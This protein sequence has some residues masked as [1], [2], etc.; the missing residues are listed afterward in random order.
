MDKQG[1]EPEKKLEKVSTN[2][3]NSKIVITAVIVI[4]LGIIFVLV[5]ILF[6]MEATNRYDNEE[7]HSTPTPTTPAEDENVIVE[8]EEVTTSYNAD[9]ENPNHAK[10]SLM[11]KYGNDDSEYVIISSA[12]ELDEFVGAINSMNADAD[13]APFIYSVDSE[14]FTTGTVIAVAKEDAGLDKMAIDEVYRDGEYNI[15]IIGHY[16]SPYD[17]LTVS[18][19]VS[20]IQI[21]NIQPKSVSLVWDEGTAVEPISP[22][23]PGEMVGKKPIIY[24]YPEKTTNV[25]V[26]LSNPERITVDYPDYRQGW[27]VTAQ[28]DGTLTTK[29][30]KKLYALYY[31]SQNIKKYSSDSLKEGF[32]VAK[33][34]VETF[35]DQ[36]LAKL[37]LNYKEREEF[38]SYWVSALEEKPYVYIRFQTTAEIEKNMGLAISPKPDTM[39]RIMMEYKPLDKQ[40]IVKEQTLPQ[41]ERKGFTVVEWGGT[42]V[43]L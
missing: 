16:V 8:Y 1:G 14:F 12:K 33:N 2:Y 32:V 22:G 36:K 11:S 30:G 4:L 29:D 17:T 23:N 25:S 34:D 38:I 41:P 9:Q 43:K 6:G 27:S 31:E 10:N 15:H 39:I 13:T 5:L 18:G 21:Q 20:L 26:K 19:Q 37:G 40:I 7:P 24:L 3:V 35:L 28:P 42:E